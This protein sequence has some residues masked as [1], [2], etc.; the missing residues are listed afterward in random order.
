MA[1]LKSGPV[2]SLQVSRNGSFTCPFIHPQQPLL[3][4]PL[5]VG[6]LTKSVAPQI[7]EEMEEAHA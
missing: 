4:G 7:T 6:F 3:E 2:A 5:S 1:L